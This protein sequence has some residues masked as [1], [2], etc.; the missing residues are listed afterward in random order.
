MQDAAEF[1]KNA[2]K[3][4]KALNKVHFAVLDKAQY[5]KHQWLTVCKIVEGEVQSLAC[6]ADMISVFFGGY[7]RDTWE[8]SLGYWQ[9]RGSPTMQ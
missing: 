5:E 8:E 7:D 2:P 9:E 6:T 3:P 4:P 1:V